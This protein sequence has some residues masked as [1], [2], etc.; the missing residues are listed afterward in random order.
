[1]T[2]FVFSGCLYFFS[3]KAKIPLLSVDNKYEWDNTDYTILFTFLIVAIAS[4]AYPFLN[5]G[6]LTNHGY[7]FTSLFAHDFIS[8]VSFTASVSHELPP[9]HFY[10]SGKTMQYYWISYAFPALIYS[11]SKFKISLQNILLLTSILQTTLFVCILYSTFRLFIRNK[12]VLV[13]VM[14]LGLCAYSYNWFYVL[15]K[16]IA[17]HAMPE[18]YLTVLVKR[19]LLEFSNIAH[20]YYRLFLFQPQSIIALSTLLVVMNILYDCSFNFRS[21]LTF[22]IGIL[23]GI[24]LGLQSYTGMTLILW[25]LLTISIYAFIERKESFLKTVKTLLILT[26]PLL[27]LIFIYFL[28]GIFSFSQDKAIKLTTNKISV[29]YAPLFFPLEYGPMLFLGILGSIIAFKNSYFR[30]LKPILLLG[31]LSLFFILFIRHPAEKDLGILK[32]GVIFQV[33]LLIFSGIFFE[34]IWENM[35]T[36]KV[37]RILSLC[38]AFSAIP[39]FLIDIYI[40]SDIENT[41]QTS[42]V[43]PADY[44]AYRWIKANTPRNAVIQSAPRYSFTPDAYDISPIAMLGERQMAV[45]HWKLSAM[46]HDSPEQ[47]PLRYKD[48]KELFSASDLKRTVELIS[49]YDI[50]YIY[51]GQNELSLYGQSV[52]KFEEHKD[53]FD[54]IYSIDGV[55]IYKIQ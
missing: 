5:V 44:K 14:L 8:R 1:M 22:I 38:V 9:K 45:G 52:R 25:L 54:L 6:K 26:F 13:V 46:L 41:N 32:S 12:Q 15:F 48:I 20:G 17:L 34:Y 16:T 18:Q 2:L 53:L 39:T 33:A 29:Y 40:T 3:R 47:V 49:K 10:F 50:D 21:G 27:C 30:N 43:N 37:I 31:L 23:L 19:R 51:V 36:R 24:A 4:V 55:N 35:K 11:T 7:A 28:M 42:Y